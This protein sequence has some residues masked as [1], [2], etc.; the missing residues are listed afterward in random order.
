MAHDSEDHAGP[1]ALDVLA[2]S[3]AKETGISEEEA[4]ELIRL[5]GTDR[6]SLLREA[7]QLLRRRPP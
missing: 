4:R 6:N 3:V 1:Q 2:Q 5:I 7:R